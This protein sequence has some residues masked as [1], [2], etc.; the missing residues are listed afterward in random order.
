VLRT[1]ILTMMLCLLAAMAFAQPGRTVGPG[2]WFLRVT[3]P[4]G[5]GTRLCVRVY[6]N[7]NLDPWYG[8]TLYV[9]NGPER[10]SAPPASDWLAPG[11]TSD[12]IDIGQH[13]SRRPTFTG[14]RDYLAP[15]FVGAM[16]DP[17]QTGLNLRVELARGADR[18]LVR[19]IDA[20]DPH[21]TLIGFSTWLGGAP[22]LPTLGLLVPAS[23]TSRERIRTLEEAAEQQL[24]WIKS[25]GPTPRPSSHVWFISHQAMV[26]F[27]NPTRLERMQTEIVRRLG[28]GSL[29]N[30][31]NDRDD[32]GTIRAM[33]A[34][35]LQTKVVALSDDI[36]AQADALKKA[37]VWDFVRLVNFGDEIDINLTATPEQQNAAFAADLQRRGFAALDFVRPDEETKA[38][39][40]PEADRWKLVRLQGA[41]PTSKPKLLFEAAV[42]RYRLWTR[43]MADRT[44]Q[45]VAL[46]PPGVQ[47]G[48]N[49]SPHLSV[50]PNVRKWI[51][52][53]RDGGMTMPWS[54]DWWWQVPEASPQ[55]YGY[56]LD[57]LRHAADY[58]GAPSCFYAIPDN[59][60]TAEHLLRM[61]YYALAHQAKVIDHF[62]IYHQAFGTCDWID[63]LE[64]R[65]KF[66]AIHR[67]LTDVGQI[68]EELSRARMRP[69]DVAILMPIAS[70]VW[71]TEDL[72]SDPKQD[73]ANNLYHAQLNVDN[74][75]RKAVWLA[76]R[77]AHYP[78]DLVTDEDVAEGKL[79]RYKVL[80]LVGQEL[81][82][83]AVE[84]LRKWVAD[85]GTLVASGGGGLLNQYREP[86]PAMRELYGLRS[87]SLERPIRTLGP[88]ADLPKMQPLDTVR[89]TASGITIPA[90]CYKQHLTPDVSATVVGTY[91]DGAPAAL[92]R[93]VG[94]GRVLLYGTLPGLAYLKPAM[95]RRQGM[96]EAFPAVVRSLIVGPALAAGARRPVI[97]SDPLV[98]ATLQEGP[99]WAVVTLTSF[100]NRPQRRITVTLPGLVGANHVRSM[101][102]GGLTVYTSDRVPR[103]TLPV[104]QGDILL[105]GQVMF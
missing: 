90:L 96:P 39:T 42:F 78:V 13:M 58:H 50:W 37:G 95:E 103:V 46:F 6:F 1:A 93:H 19:R 80:Y 5:A 29:V 99:E 8:D 68:D 23:A 40:L 74:H 92:E 71:D 7:P 102:Q 70:D 83:E 48:A 52:M 43:E 98:E 21:P 105:V 25:F 59:G 4:A 56:L 97:T 45:A 27:K 15:V 73:K 41:L 57:A 32:I 14:S 34:T 10:E 22:T 63:F 84:P 3:N 64:S 69:A 81:L 30:Y 67:I 82:Q 60:E 65:D 16:T 100:R 85:G 61:N 53:F 17:A 33:G 2:V 20:S 91:D 101:R 44:R 62:A 31:A 86:L 28:Y 11:H 72:L 66:R 76:L 77:H 36:R 38:T 88:A 55:S 47:T 49:F 35:P 12:W 9:A 51:D 54:E 89:V 75:E 79:S 18:R 104:D 26:S 87:A 24:K 94:S